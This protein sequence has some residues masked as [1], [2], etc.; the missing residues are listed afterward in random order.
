MLQYDKSTAL[1]VTKLIAKSND[2]SFDPFYRLHYPEQLLTDRLQFPENMLSLYYIDM[3]P[4]L[5][6]QQ[7][8]QLSL[9][10]MV[11]FFSLN[12]HG[13]RALIRDMLD[14]S[15]QSGHIE[16]TELA[17]EYVHHLIHEENAHSYMLSRYCYKYA[18]GVMPDMRMDITNP[19][20][21]KIG[22]ELLF[23]T[24]IYILETF[25]SFLNSKVAYS[26]SF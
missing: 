11:N 21:S 10:E 8:W 14:R 23:Y 20:L 7:K 13:E 22:R 25:L 6:D 16:S 1:R 4:T 19:S 26:G 12:I 15:H 5:S 18:N 2:K 17:S 3:Y 9:Y 24:R